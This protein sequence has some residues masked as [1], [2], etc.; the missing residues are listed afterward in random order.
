MS[1][2][3][4]ILNSGVLVIENG[5]IVSAEGPGAPSFAPDEISDLQVWWDFSELDGN[6]VFNDLAGVVPIT[7][8]ALLRRVTDRSGNGF[9][10][11]PR[12]LIDAHSGTWDSGVRN[13]NGAFAAF[14]IGETPVFEGGAVNLENGSAMFG[15]TQIYTI[16]AVAQTPAVKLGF[17]Q[18]LLSMPFPTGCQIGIGRG[19]AD[20]GK[21]RF[22]RF[23]SGTVNN[24]LG[25]VAWGT[26]TGDWFFWLAEIDAANSRLIYNNEDSDPATT[27]NFST[28]TQS[29]FAVGAGLDLFAN[30]RS[31]W[32]AY[33]GECFAYDKQL[34]QNEKD[35]LFN[36]LASKWT[37]TESVNP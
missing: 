37:L 19:T 32:N 16:G 11:R 30:A 24:T 15:T 2:I 25:N 12:D 34:T 22:Q 20:S 35:G 27:H 3:I 21:T 17:A 14:G 33:I 36:H 28:T 6:F 18:E 5:G 7:N 9:F 8:G 31:S 29:G 26:L 13:G 4:R 1:G 23:F 10:G